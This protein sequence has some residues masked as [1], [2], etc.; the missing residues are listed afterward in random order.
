MRDWLVTVAVSVAFASIPAWFYV[1]RWSIRRDIERRGGQLRH[2]SLRFLGNRGEWNVLFRD[3]EG[4]SNRGVCI[5]R[6]W[7]CVYWRFIEP[8]TSTTHL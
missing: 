7:T 8:T 4:V 1:A 5:V 2:L 6:F 3:A